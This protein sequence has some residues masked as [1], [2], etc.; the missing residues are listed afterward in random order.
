MVRHVTTSDEE[1]APASV[2]VKRE[3]VV[4]KIKKESVKRAQRRV[5]D[6]SDDEERSQNDEEQ[7]HEGS[8]K[9]HKRSRINKKGDSRP[10]TEPHDS[11]DEQGSGDD[12]DEVPR[13]IKTQPRDV[14][15]SVRFLALSTPLTRLQ[16]HSRLYRSYPAQEFRHLRLHR[17]L[18]WPI[19]QYAD[20]TEW[21]GQELCRLCHLPRAE[22][23]PKRAFPQRSICDSSKSPH[24]FSVVP[25]KSVF[26]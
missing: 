8:P 11:D 20:R 5:E 12:E 4:A 15:G 25:T 2:R 19:P 1:A 13:A 24:R 22:F 6:D 23:S 7:A 17:I 9:G 18:P 14:D 21:N 26:L 10:S 16:L 3:K